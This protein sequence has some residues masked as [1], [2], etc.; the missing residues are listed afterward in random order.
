MLCSS[1][2][3]WPQP[4][5]PVQLASSFIVFQPHQ[6]A[7]KS[8]A[9]GNERVLLNQ[10]YDIFKSNVEALGEKDTWSGVTDI[11]KFIVELQ[12]KVIDTNLSLHTDESY[13]LTVH[14]VESDITA[15]IRANSY[16]GA[17]HGL[18]TLSQLIWKDDTDHGSVLK[19][20]KGATVQDS[21]AFPYR[22]LMLDTA[23]Q[24]FTVPAIKRL[25]IGMSACKLNVFHWHLTDSQSFPFDSPRRP[26]MARYGASSPQ[27]IYSASDVKDVVE[28][29]RI[30]GIRVLIEIDT[31]AHSG[32]GWNWGPAHGMGELALC[33]NQ[34]PW[35]LYCGEP[36]CG[37]L[38]P[39]NPKVYEV[40]LDL[41]KDIL[42]LSKEK[43]IFHIGGDEVNLKCWEQILKSKVTN[44]IEKYI[45][46]HDVWGNFTLKAI[47]TL[48]TA[49]QETPVPNIVIW[50]SDLTKRPYSERYLN[51]KNII[52]QI[53]GGSTWPET[54]DL[55]EDGY[56]VIISHVDAWYLDCGFGKWR[57]NGNAACD[58]YRTWQTVYIH[59]PWQTLKIMEKNK[60]NILG[61]EGCLWTEQV[62]EESLDTRLWPRAAAL[63][64]RLW[65]D[66][67]IKTEDRNAYDNYGSTF[68]PT[69]N[70]DVYTRLVTQ[71]GR[72][73]RRG[74]KSEAMW[75]LWCVQNPGMCL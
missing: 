55:L 32:N 60:R 53:W 26:Q 28:F 65:T 30:R 16:F 71:R 57:E 39:S 62:G 11:Q 34:Q 74:V 68:S 38:N 45:D 42:E 37:Q 8:P 41:Y 44:N 61:G 40:L 67:E 1:T 70:E 47:K 63:A 19:I 7:L 31:P 75:P 72:L 17:R 66:P 59:R 43:E 49:N 25:L 54:E 6:L 23:R 24:F 69:I 58:P 64:E 51:K 18:E 2:Q 20:L 9:Q 27:M 73:V 5:G 21:P 22:G 29:A 10:A 48:K 46:L 12:V 56:K 15:T 50:S 4:T 14:V 36:P 33:V 35:E 52:I 3:L 13:N